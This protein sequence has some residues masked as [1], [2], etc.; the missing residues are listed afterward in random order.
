[1]KN[2]KLA[3]KR[4]YTESEMVTNHRLAVYQGIAIVFTTMER[5]FGWKRHRLQEL[6]AATKVTAEKPP[7][8]GKN[9]DVLS[10]MRRF[11]NDYHFDLKDIDLHVEVKNHE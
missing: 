4:L 7:A 10:E 1:M 5:N 8:I 3:K 11:Q 6:F 2:P 9:A